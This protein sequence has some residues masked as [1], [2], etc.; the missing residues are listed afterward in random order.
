MRISV[1]ISTYN[2]PKWLDHVLCGY[3]YQTDQDFELVIADDGSGDATREV[4]DKHQAYI[5]KLQHIWHPDDGFQKSRILNLATQAA[6]GDYLIFTD[7]DCIPPPDFIGLH[8]SC[9]KS[10]HYLSGGYFKLP[11]TTSTA[12]SEEDIQ[13]GQVFSLRWLRR[14]GL[15]LSFKASRLSASP[16]LRTLLDCC[17]PT[18][19]TW[20]GN[21]SSAFK[22][23][24]LAVNGHDERMQYGGQDVEMGYRLRHRGLRPI[25]VRYRALVL[26]LDHAR[27]YANEDSIAKNRA[28]RQKTLETQSKWTA[29]GILKS[30]R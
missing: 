11:M 8:R 2:N 5:P 26:H 27:G 22:S 30:E 25:R 24:I 18:K 16:R 17:I 12:I 23:D 13:T 29:H 15:P 10:G 14:H 20:N 7:G 19:A 21:N 28:I 6:S 9:A 3:R 1:I 4:V